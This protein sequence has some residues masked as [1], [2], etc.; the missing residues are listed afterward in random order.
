MRCFLFL[1][2]V[3]AHAQEFWP[4]AHG[5]DTVP[6][7]HYEFIPEKMLEE[8]KESFE[9]MQKWLYGCPSKY[10]IEECATA[11]K[12]RKQGQSTTSQT[13]R[14]EKMAEFIAIQMDKIR[15]V[16][17]TEETRNQLLSELRSIE[18]DADFYNGKGH[19][20]SISGE[21][22]GVRA[23]QKYVIFTRALPDGKILFVFSYFAE[24]SQLT[25]AWSWLVH[26]H[27]P[28][29]I[30]RW[31][32]Y[33]LYLEISSEI[34]AYESS[35][36][37]S[38]RWQSEVPALP[39]QSN[40]FVTDL[41]I[42]HLSWQNWGGISAILVV[43]LKYAYANFASLVSRRKSNS[44]RLQAED[45]GIPFGGDASFLQAALPSPSRGP[46]SVGSWSLMS[47]VAQSDES[48]SSLLSASELVRCFLAC[49]RFYGKNGELIEAAS[50]R[51]GSKI[52]SAKGSALTVKDI[53][54]YPEA[55]NG[56]Q[57]HQ[58][59]ELCTEAEKLVVTSD[60]RVMVQRGAQQ[61]SIRADILC[62]GDSVIV[63]GGVSAK[64][65]KVESFT[66][67]ARVAQITF[68]PDEPVEAFHSPKTAILSK[69][70]GFSK[71]RR[72]NP[73]RRQNNLLHDIPCAFPDTESD[74]DRFEWS[75]EKS[76]KQD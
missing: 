19:Y 64:L 72:G 56:T 66:A 32:T 53:K 11:E 75:L 74:S 10:T 40:K 67:D 42:D 23:L 45:D 5:I 31:L 21:P 7:L 24:E 70:H 49:S 39:W 13:I 12:L 44:G 71:S 34:Q 17:L 57:E 15:H 28:A 8:Y 61:Q 18:L 69:A 37:L 6:S 55:E 62:R 60:H 25:T 20:V 46:S 48:G 65:Q 73:N 36:F 30:E 68:D 52:R 2:G 47:S 27:E 9:E 59:V 54:F 51:K 3:L 29:D 1:G 14:P 22:G 38:P 50:L 43:L 16:P 76:N 4:A 63:S 35:K 58:F 33:K 41:T 26:N